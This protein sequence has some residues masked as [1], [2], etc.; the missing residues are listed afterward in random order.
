MRPGI[1]VQRE[2]RIERTAHRPNGESR[3][4]SAPAGTHYPSGLTKAPSSTKPKSEHRDGRAESRPPT[5]PGSNGTRT[6]HQGRCHRSMKEWRRPSTQKTTATHPERTKH[7]DHGHRRPN[8][9][10]SSEVETTKSTEVHAHRERCTQER[11][12]TKGSGLD[13]HTQTDDRRPS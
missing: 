2:P 10:R 11:P 9:R 13:P 5:A 8:P 7:G 4:P 12:P 6:A 1:H 3:R